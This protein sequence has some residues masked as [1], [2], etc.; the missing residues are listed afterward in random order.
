MDPGTW[1]TVLLLEGIGMT[2]FGAAG[3][4]SGEHR[5]HVIGLRRPRILHVSLRPRYPDHLISIAFAGVVLLLIG[6]YLVSHT[7]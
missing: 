6:V 4:G 5:F 2:L 7:Y 1:I 3:W